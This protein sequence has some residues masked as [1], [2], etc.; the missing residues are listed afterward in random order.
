MRGC[1]AA[2]NQVSTEGFVLVCVCLCL[3]SVVVLSGY[4]CQ[5][6][7]LAKQYTMVYCGTANS[8]HATVQ[9]GSCTTCLVVAIPWPRASAVSAMFRTTSMQER[10]TNSLAPLCVCVGVQVWPLVLRLHPAHPLQRHQQQQEAPRGCLAGSPPHSSTWR[11]HAGG[12]AAASPGQCP[13]AVG[14]VVQR[15]DRCWQGTG[16]TAAA[17]CR[18]GPAHV[19]SRRWV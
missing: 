4:A 3:S 16:P 9:L 6:L 11:P 7:Q 2:C 15:T 8:Q 18:P 14:A 19:C 1:P 13:P 10:C 17:A 5:V 12:Q